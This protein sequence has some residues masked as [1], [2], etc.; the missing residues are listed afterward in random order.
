MKGISSIIIILFFCTFGHMA[1]AQKYEPKF[2]FGLNFGRTFLLGKCTEFQNG[3]GGGAGFFH[4]QAGYLLNNEYTIHAT[5]QLTWVGNNALY[6]TYGHLFPEYTTYYI[7]PSTMLSFYPTINKKI[8][9]DNNQKRYWLNIF[10][11]VGVEMNQTFYDRSY[12][13]KPNS[14]ESVTNRGDSHFSPVFVLGGSYER[15]VYK[16]LF[17]KVLFDYQ[18]SNFGTED[19]LFEYVDI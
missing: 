15:F 14:F 2:T 19:I 11:G 7:N 17:I 5:L 8:F 13:S 4:F 16:G 10:G 18:L 6:N 3:L 12:F 9:L 1:S